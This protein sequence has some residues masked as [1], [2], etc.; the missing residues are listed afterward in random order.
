M[1]QTFCGSRCLRGCRGQREYDSSSGVTAMSEDL[2]EALRRQP[3]MMQ[4][5]LTQGFVWHSRVVTSLGQECDVGTQ[6]TPILVTAERAAVTAR[7][8]RIS[9]SMI[10]FW[11][12]EHPGRAGTSSCC[13]LGPDCDVLPTTTKGMGSGAV[14][15]HRRT[16]RHPCDEGDVLRR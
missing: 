9:R 1:P 13:A 11:W 5:T 16:A 3:V 12:F 4:T 14:L 8:F 7:L 2:V 6:S 15:D 10:T